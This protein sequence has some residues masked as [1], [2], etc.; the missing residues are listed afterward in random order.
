MSRDRKKNDNSL[1]N[2]L[3]KIA[4]YTTMPFQ[5]AVIVGLGV[6]LGYEID[7]WLNTRPVFII[8]LGVLFTLLAIYYA[9]KDIIK[10]KK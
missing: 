6:F 9:V 1:K 10:R 5:M 2:D 4:F 7:K 3:K 8:I